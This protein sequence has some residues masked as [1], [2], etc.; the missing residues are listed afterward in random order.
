MLR[1]HLTQRRRPDLPKRS[2][3]IVQQN[4][5]KH[6]QWILWLFLVNL[7]SRFSP[8]WGT[9]Y[10]RNV[11]LHGNK[12]YQSLD[13]L[14]HPSGQCNITALTAGRAGSSGYTTH[15]RISLMCTIY[16]SLSNRSF[17]FPWVSWNDGW[18]YWLSVNRQAIM[19]ELVIRAS[20][21]IIRTHGGV[22]ECWSCWISSIITFDLKATLI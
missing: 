9:F 18:Q 13:R 22:N 10:F 8:S 3:S 19:Q 12:M 4:I 5:L 11:T 16:Q 2:V 20:R 17:F 15:Y 14:V 1:Y 6:Q 7:H 21:R